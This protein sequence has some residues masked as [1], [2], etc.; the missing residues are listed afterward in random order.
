M[1]EEATKLHHLLEDGL[2]TGAFLVQVQNKL[3]FLLVYVMYLR[4]HV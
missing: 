4:Y 2:N 1:H 3:V